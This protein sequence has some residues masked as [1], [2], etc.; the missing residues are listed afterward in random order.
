MVEKVRI[1]PIA[2]VHHNYILIIA[3]EEFQSDPPRA[4]E[5]VLTVIVVFEYV[6]LLSW[7]CW[8]TETDQ[9][10]NFIFV[11]LLYI[12]SDR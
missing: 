3:S 9:D 10:T 8:A 11:Y 6:L 12:S 7:K 1:F 4:R 2:V 5:N